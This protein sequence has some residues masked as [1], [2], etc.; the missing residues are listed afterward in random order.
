[1]DVSAGSSSNTVNSSSSSD[2]EVKAKPT[3]VKKARIS[4][5]SGVRK[6]R[7]KLQMTKQKH[8][9]TRNPKRDQHHSS[10]DSEPKHRK[11][12]SGV[13]NPHKRK[14]R[15]SPSTSL[16]DASSETGSDSDASTDESRISSNESSSE[17]L[18]CSSRKL[19][20]HSKPSAK[21]QRKKT[22]HLHK[23]SKGKKLRAVFREHFAALVLLVSCPEQLASQLYSR[24]LISPATLDKVF[25][26]PTSQQHLLLDLDRKIRADPE[27]LFVFVQVIQGDPSLEELAAM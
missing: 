15:Y 1:M 19:R 17:E 9:C 13:G 8:H 11:S 3:N 16:S 10:S 24:S 23:T 14:R 12:S 27:K 7:K 4:K 18:E 5:S 20:K 2:T 26:L 25:T 6:H 21:H 22:K